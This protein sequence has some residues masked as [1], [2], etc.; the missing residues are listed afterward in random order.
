MMLSA[1]LARIEFEGY[2][3]SMATRVL[4]AASSPFFVPHLHVLSLIQVDSLLK[5]D[6]PAWSFD[7]PSLL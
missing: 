1:T 3:K 2:P 4:V 6:L 7:H 5:I